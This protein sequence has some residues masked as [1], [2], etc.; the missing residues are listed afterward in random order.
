MPLK[1]HWNMPLKSTIIS[2]VLISGVQSFAPRKRR[3]QG[4]RLVEL[5]GT[6]RAP[7][8]HGPTT[9][10]ASAARDA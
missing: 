4:G 2:E 3:R 1:I 9:A 7:V 10:Q 8:D 6:K 5:D